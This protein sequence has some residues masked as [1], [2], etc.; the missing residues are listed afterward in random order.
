MNW[1]LLSTIFRSHSIF[2]IL[3]HNYRISYEDRSSGT[4]IQMQMIIA[5]YFNRV[6]YF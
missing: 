5:T 2:S 1:I 3:R 4:E 6:Y